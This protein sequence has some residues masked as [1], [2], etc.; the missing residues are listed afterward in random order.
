MSYSEISGGVTAAR[1]FLAGSAYC[2]IKASNPDRPDIAL[3]YSLQSA[4]GAGT[5]TT[6]RVKAAPVRVSMM[7]AR[8]ADVRAI[9][10]NAGNANACTGV[11]GI[12]N[13]KRMVAATA[14]TLGVKDR[15]VFVCST[16]RI[17][18][19][20]PIEKIEK[21]ISSLPAV[22]SESGSNAAAFAI[23][24]SD[25]KPKEIAVEFEID[26]TLIRIGGIAKGAGM[27]DPNMAT[28]LCF[29]TTDAVI[30]KKLLQR[31]LSVSVEQ[32]FNRITVDGDMST[33]DT[34]LM[35]ANGAAGTK[36]L[37]YNSPA[38]KLFQRA[39]DHVTRHLA[40][41]IVEDGEGVTKFVEVHV[42][43]AASLTDA[44]RAAEA[45]AN[46]NLVKCAWF[47]NDPNWGRIMDAVGYSGAKMREELIDIYYDGVLGVK[48]GMASKTPFAKLQ[49]IVS[50]QRFS[51]T[52]NLHVG[53]A[54]YTVY[55]TDLSVDYVKLN[56]G[57]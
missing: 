40:R 19:Q 33:N 37:R 43:G 45:V 4:V 24:T 49:E 30:E 14:G 57:E 1:G 35:L 32:S 17:G 47:G 27:I 46:S 16:G 39:L 22:C 20:L 36:P 55:T 15:Q 54:E 5:F 34:V 51:I 42:H 41:M 21:T 9:I 25:T 6:N 44:R 28:M 12:E 10:A 53:S 23:M 13:A 31:A 29:I 48:G 7:T 2:G 52:I 8:S 18:V 38:F 56:M 3:I 50:A 11:R 26:G